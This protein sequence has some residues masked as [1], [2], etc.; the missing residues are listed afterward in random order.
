MRETDVTTTRDSLLCQACGACC[1]HS[2]EWPRFTLEDDAEIDLIPA[3]LIDD[4]QARMRC[5][6]NRCAALGGEIG[7]ATACTI[8]DV[9]PLV[10]RDCVPGDDACTI[11]RAAR[12]MA[13]V[14]SVA[15]E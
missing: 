12:G 1:S 13:P 14:V 5:E 11:A 10:C 8:Y 7:V 15:A 4:S 6:G 2:H 9:R 3:A